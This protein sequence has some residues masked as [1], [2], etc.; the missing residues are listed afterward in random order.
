VTRLA[1]YPT[2]FELDL[3]AMTALDGDDVDPMMFRHQHRMRRGELDEIPPEM[4]RFGIRFADGSTVTNTSDFDY[5]RGRPN[6]PVMHQA[7]GGGGG[8]QWR[9]SHWVWPLPASGPLTLVCEWPAMNIAF[10]ESELDAHPILDAA[11]RAQV[12]FT[13][14]HLPEPPDDD[15]SGPPTLSITSS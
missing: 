5:E 10:T 3:L 8:G 12:I 9:Q 15:A 4:L 14:A 2:G 6:G 13:D 1:A 11:R 7:G